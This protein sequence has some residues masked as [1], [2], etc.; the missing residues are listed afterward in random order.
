MSTPM[1]ELDDDRCW[2]VLE[3]RA[4][5]ETAFVYAVRTTGIYCRPGCPSRR[6]KRQN[7]LFF[8]T[9]EAAGGAGFRPCKRCRPEAKAG[10]RHAGSVA[11]ACRRIETE[12][13]EPTLAKLAAE[14]ELSPY[15][16]QRV[17]KAHVGLSPKQFA[18]AVRSRRLKETLESGARVTDA[19]YEAGYGGP[20][21]AYEAAERGMGMTPTR[22]RDGGAGESI[23]HAVADC[24]LGRVIVAGTRRGI[25]AIEFGEVDDRLVAGL[26]K[27]FPKASLAPA[28]PEFEGWLETVLAFIET[29]ERGLDLPLDIQGTAFQERVWS[30][31]RRIPPG[32]TVS[33]AELA[34]TI[35]QPSA[36]RA[37]ARACA[38]NPIAVAIPCHR[39]IRADGGLSGYR[40]GA[41][42]KRAILA[43]EAGLAK[44]EK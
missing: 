30:A 14:A 31:L 2:A 10:S 44:F 22:W 19:I 34:A 20:S 40:W 15:H 24:S 9:A 42:R 36:A 39:A 27:R 35:G 16:F 21:R 23:W 13:T 17:F 26:R 11:R 7:V 1:A 12:E 18:K 43:Q 4:A 41:S 28:D 32:T 38:S 3:R 5:P 33:Y 37:V 8:R 6:P 29:P 25:C